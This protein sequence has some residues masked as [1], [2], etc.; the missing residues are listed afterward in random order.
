MPSMTMVLLKRLSDSSEI[1]KTRAKLK[2]VECVCACVSERATDIPDVGK[3]WQGC[4][5]VAWCYLRLR[6]LPGD[7]SPRTQPGISR[8]YPTPLR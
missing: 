3:T 4:R 8:Q 6:N 2:V 5:K 7:P 1:V